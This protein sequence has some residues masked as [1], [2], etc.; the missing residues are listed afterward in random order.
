[1]TEAASGLLVGCFDNEASQITDLIGG[2]PS[3]VGG[4]HPNPL[5]EGADDPFLVGL[6]LI[7]IRTE[8]ALAAGGDQTMTSTA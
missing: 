5:I 6:Q 1:M 2:K 7:E 4:H 8:A 3:L